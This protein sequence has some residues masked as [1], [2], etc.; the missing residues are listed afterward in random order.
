MLLKCTAVKQLS[1][2]RNNVWST[3]LKPLHVI[4]TFQLWKRSEGNTNILKKLIPTD[5]VK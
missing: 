1:H 2:D 3:A 4:L 5:V